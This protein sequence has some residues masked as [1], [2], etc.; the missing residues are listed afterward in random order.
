M[1][2]SLSHRR[3]RRLSSLSPRTLM[4]G[5]CAT[6]SFL[7]NAAKAHT[8]KP[9]ASTESITVQDAIKARLKT[10]TKSSADN[11]TLSNDPGNSSDMGSTG[12][13]LGAL[14]ID[15]S[16][17][18]RIKVAGILINDAPLRV[19]N[20]DILAPIVGDD[21]SLLSKL[22][23][24]ASRVAE[25]NYQGNLNTPTETQSFQLN[26]APRPPII[27]TVGQA[28]AYVAG[29]EQQLR[30][31]PLVI[32]NKIYLPVFSIAPLLGAAVRLEPDGTLDITPTIQSVE[33]FPAQGYT[34]VTVKT[35]ARIPEGAVLKGTLDNPPKLYFDFSGYSMGFDAVNSTGERV[36]STGLNDVQQ[37]RAGMP[38]SFPDVTRIAIDLKRDIASQI[39]VQPLPDRTMFAV[40][41][42][43]S[44]TKI[45]PGEVTI[46]GPNDERVQP[47]GGSLRGVTIVI[48]A[49][50]GGYDSGAPGSAILQSSSAIKGVSY[51]VTRSAEKHYTLDMARRLRAD[52]EARGATVLMTRDGDYFVTLPG[53]VDFANSHHADIFFSIHI[54]S[55][56]RSSTG[57]TTHFYTA[58]SLPLAREVQSE[59]ARA[60]GV[61][62]RGVEQ[63]RFFVI[64]K[65]WMP[66]VLTESCFIT[67]PGEEAMLMNPNWRQRVANGMA[68]GISNYVRK[69]GV[70]N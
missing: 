52:L 57:T 51:G 3:S 50:H 15:L 42:P 23:A 7:G 29:Q 28:T 36:V 67:N 34:V 18:R 32:G 31:A 13:T 5:V 58:Q 43:N 24:T 17:V 10:Y 6:F 27:L 61:K 38:Q 35:S 40:L 39:T 19:G 46:P 60:T 8:N 14:P 66:S 62:S 63:S 41:I 70:R 16:Q 22:G 55:Y 21:S 11:R 4:L 59:L 30:A 54:D 65:T 53:R 44:Q 45:P 69:Y 2:H 20:L 49:G 56:L 37:V 1:K 47:T 33:V 68:Q 26:L 48:D 64:R 25:K 9:Q 12:Q